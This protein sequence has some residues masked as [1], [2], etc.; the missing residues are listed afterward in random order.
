MSL[1][2][3]EIRLFFSAW[4]GFQKATVCDTGK[5]SFDTQGKL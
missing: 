5:K 3:E 2:Y 1:L 4:A